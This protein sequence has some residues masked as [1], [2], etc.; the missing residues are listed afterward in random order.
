MGKICPQIAISLQ[1]LLDVT[2]GG[3]VV[4]SVQLP[5]KILA[6]TFPT[7][8][9]FDAYICTVGWAEMFS[10]EVIPVN[11]DWRDWVFFPA[12]PTE[13]HNFS[14]LLCKLFSCG[15]FGKR[16][17]VVVRGK[18][19]VLFECDNLCCILHLLHVQKHGFFSLHV[20]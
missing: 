12:N 5:E 13:S 9:Y 16:R 17:H 6:F 8:K 19:F 10:T 2:K 11:T 18:Y 14:H 3:V 7:Q 4:S 1:W 20:L 15:Y